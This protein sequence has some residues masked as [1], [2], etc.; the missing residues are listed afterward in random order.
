L[1]QDRHFNIFVALRQM[2]I[3][4][5][6]TIYLTSVTELYQL[7]KMPVLIEHFIEHKEKAMSL[8]FWE[9]LDMHYAHQ[10]SEDGDL[11]RDMQLPFKAHDGCSSTYISAQ[12]INSSNE[13]STKPLS[14]TICFYLE[15]SGKFLNSAFH[16]AIWQPP[17]SC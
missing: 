16:S 8:S 17:K 4:F 7:L 9:F 10:H 13:L 6:L 11:S 12:L 15:Y 2:G 5:L 1:E 3:I 14:P